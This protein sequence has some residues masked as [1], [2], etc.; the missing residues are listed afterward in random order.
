[1]P[2]EK[3]EIIQAQLGNDAGTVGM[4]AWSAVQQG[5]EIIN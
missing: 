2:I 1:M 5:Y 3:V 4:A